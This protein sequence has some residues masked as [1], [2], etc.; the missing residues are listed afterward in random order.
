VPAQ[1]W[2][3]RLIQVLAALAGTI[4]WIES[5]RLAFST[6]WYAFGDTSTWSAVVGLTAGA[7]LVLAGTIDLGSPAN[8]KSGSLLVA[9]GTAWL[10]TAWDNPAAPTW[11]FV[12]GRILD[13][14]WPVLMAHALLTRYGALGR[15]ERAVLVIAYACTICL[16][17]AVSLVSDPVTSGCAD[18]PANPLL[19]ADVSGMAAGLER[20]ATLT[21]PVW[22]MLLAGALATCLFR[23]T[24]ARRRIELPITTIG[25][26]LL[27]VVAAGY[28]RVT[29]RGLPETDDAALWAAESGLLLLLALATGWPALSLALTRQ[30]VAEFV[31]QASAVPPIGGLGQVLGDALHDPT[32]RLLYRRPGRK[33][34]V[35]D[36]RRRQPNPAQRPTHASHPRSRHR[37]LPRSRRTPT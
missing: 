21:G 32:A 14:V 9:A 25:V 34:R 15:A 16:H 23:S 22:A 1:V 5:A 26:L 31:V 20:T 10:I 17:L 6:S 4:V 27:L 8:R 2:R 7:A 3:I 18:C 36:R 28:V 13:T 19:I 24:S 37:R 11:V 12:A 35:S 30:R 33:R 29:V